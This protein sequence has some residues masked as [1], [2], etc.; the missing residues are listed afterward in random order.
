MLGPHLTRYARTGALAL[1]LLSA[2]PAVAN[3][4]LPGGDTF[5]DGHFEGIT[6]GVAGI[7][8]LTPLLY[9]GLGAGSETLPPLT[10][11]IGTGLEFEWHPTFGSPVVPVIYRLTNTE[12]QPYSDLRFML[13]LKAKGQP[14]FLDTAAVHG[15]NSPAGPGDPNNF[16]IFNFDAPGDKPLQQIANFNGL[17][18]SIAPACLSGC[19]SDLALQWNRAE[20]G[21]NQTWEINVMLVD[22]PRLVIGG[23]YLVASSLSPDGT[24]LVFGNPQLIPEPQTFAMLL[25]GL[26][27]LAFLRMRRA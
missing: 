3:I 4:G 15:F 17:N 7:A 23:R 8:N 25:A 24:Q 1:G 18:N 22:D 16:Q 21:P 19:F 20:L 10:Q 27:L 26:G 14:N 13:D 12:S 2:P 11:I 6:Y 9:I 5:L